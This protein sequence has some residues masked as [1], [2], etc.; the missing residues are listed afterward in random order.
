MVERTPVTDAEEIWLG[1]MPFRVQGDI[2]EEMSNMFSRKVNQG[3][4]RPD[5]HPTF[6]TSIQADWSGGGLVREGNP[7]QDQARFDYSTCE[8][9]YPNALTLP[10]KTYMIDPPSGEFG[11]PVMVGDYNGKFY[12]TWGTN[13]YR[14]DTGTSTLVLIGDLG[15]SPTPSGGR[16]YREFGETS[17]NRLL[18]FIPLVAGYAVID[19]SETISTGTDTDRVVAFEVWDNKIFKL[20]ADGSLWWALEEPATSAGWTLTA[21]VPDGSIPRRMVRYMDKSNNPCLFIVTDAGTWK[22]DFGNS[23]LHMDDLDYPRHPSQGLAAKVHNQAVF[24]SAAMTIYEYNNNTINVGAGLDARDGMPSEWRGNIVDL[25]SA[26]PGLFALVHGSK[27]SDEEI[28]VEDYYMA[29]GHPD[30][31]YT[32]QQNSNNVLM[33]DTGFG[34]HHRWSGEG[35]PPTNIKTSVAEGTYRI[36]WGS[37]GKLMY[38]RLSRVPYNPADPDTRGRVFE[39]KCTHYSSWNAWG[40]VNQDKIMKQIE[41]S[42]KRLRPG[43]YVEVAVQINDPDG[44]WHVFPPITT[45]GRTRIPLGLDP[46]EPVLRNGVGHYKGI[47]HE[48]YRLRITIVGVPD[49]PEQAPMVEWHAVVARRWLRPQRIWRARLDLTNTTKDWPTEKLEEHLFNMSVAQEAVV[50]QKDDRHYMVE[51]VMRTGPQKTGRD[52]RY[53]RSVTLMEAND[54]DRKSIR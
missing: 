30:P 12:L 46:N 15:S 34:W 50:F 38:Q 9:A 47:R 8:T 31:F 10:P 53:I 7:A 49:D 17:G 5:D 39:R 28:S 1:G 43:S 24:V 37:N 21:W 35:A 2:T 42:V 32:Q 45:N 23:M 41:V 3:D 22:H 36:Y 14:F 25:E 26:L 27:D 48:R 13:L 16:V 52:K 40:W 18:L 20:M 54:L 11:T 6:T 4:P 44:D 33:I 19:D 51:I 29:L